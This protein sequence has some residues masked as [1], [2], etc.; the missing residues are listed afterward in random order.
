MRRVNRVHLLFLCYAFLSGCYSSSG[1]AHDG[2]QNEAQEDYPGDGSA[3][4]DFDPVED[5]TDD[6][7]ADPPCELVILAQSQLTHNLGGLDEAESPVLAWTGSELG[8][9]W[10][11]RE[12][13]MESSKV[14]FTK[15]SLDGERVIEDVLVSELDYPEW[16]S[17]VFSGSEFGM[18]WLRWT[19]STDDRKELI[20]AR[21][22]E[23]G[24]KIGGDIV[25]KRTVDWLSSPRIV[26]GSDGYGVVFCDNS[27]A[28]AYVVFMT[29]DREG[30]QI[31]DEVMINNYNI[32]VNCITEMVFSGSEFAVAWYEPN[33]FY[34]DLDFARV[35]DGARVGDIERLA[36]DADSEGLGMAFS[37]SEYAIVYE[38]H[39][40]DWEDVYFI[41]VS[42][43]GERIG[44]DVRLPFVTGSSPY[45]NLS[46]VFSGSE[47][48]VA[49]VLE[50]VSETGLRMGRFAL[51]GSPVG[52][53]IE[54][55]DGALRSSLAAAGNDYALAWDVRRNI[56]FSLVGC[57]LP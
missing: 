30:N 50:E 17:M 41:R 13:G 12:N 47:Y 57:A 56:Y 53:H 46:I 19:G 43:G 8:L 5:A 27:L 2:D 44:E 35:R 3:P 49:Y 42:P 34:F 52:D 48:A 31:Y 55:S 33:D 23:Q 25:L 7:S 11:D 32:Y 4:G 16:P 9:A 38:G 54:I 36:A 6:E 21:V 18:T 22:S 14:L 15:L 37:G 45:E 39:R 51:D 24:E 28:S 20:F 10:Q 29:L 1:M 26:A 40:N